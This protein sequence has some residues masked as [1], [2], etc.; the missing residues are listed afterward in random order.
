MAFVGSGS[1][2]DACKFL[3]EQVGPHP[4]LLDDRRVTFAAAGM[5]RSRLLLLSPR[6]WRNAWRARREGFR[7]EGLQGDAWQLG[8]VV[9]VAADG[10]MVWRQVER[11][12]GDELDL[13]HVAELV[14]QLSAN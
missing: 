6:M 12:A 2:A 7:Q 10:R 13:R 4:L 9:V 11:V 8:G 14:R 1:Q 3:Q 5:R